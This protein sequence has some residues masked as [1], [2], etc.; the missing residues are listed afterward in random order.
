MSSSAWPISARSFCGG[1]FPQIDLDPALEDSFQIEDIAELE[2]V[3]AKLRKHLSHLPEVA[4][5]LPV[6]SLWVALLGGP[7][8][9]WLLG[10]SIVELVLQSVKQVLP[11]PSS[12]SSEMM[13][14]L[15]RAWVEH[16][17]SVVDMSV[18]TDQADAVV[19]DICAKAA[20]A[21]IVLQE[22]E[23]ALDVHAQD[24]LDF[25]TR[26][27]QADKAL[28]RWH[29]LLDNVCRLPARTAPGRHAKHRLVELLTKLEPPAPGGTAVERVFRSA[30]E[31]K[32]RFGST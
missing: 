3:V 18:T 20:A 4:C 17:C 19:I 8:S 9:Q 27:E 24:A 7:A 11:S 16:G 31:D 22:M 5:R 13:A 12:A 28:R 1:D 21:F 2:S 6:L 29:D 25:V 15:E 23:R 32:D 26:C 10:R 30:R 14:G